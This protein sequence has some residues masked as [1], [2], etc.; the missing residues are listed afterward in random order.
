M[1]RYRWELINWSRILFLQKILCF[2]FNKY[3]CNYTRLSIL[4]IGKKKSITTKNLSNQ[5]ELTKPIR[6]KK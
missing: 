4:K 2:K 6:K 1:N 5:N 3:N